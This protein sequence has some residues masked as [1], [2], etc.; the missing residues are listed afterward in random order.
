MIACAAGARARFPGLL[1]AALLAPAAA[2]QPYDVPYVPTPQVVVEEMLR[3]AQV[4]PDDYVIDLGC[5]DGR[6]PVTAASHFGAR[7]LGVDIDPGR[8]AESHANA[9]AAG[10]TARVEFVH[11]NLFDLD[12]SRAS[13]VT[14][15]LLPDINLKL[16]PKLL[17]T[18]KPGTRVVSHAFPMGDWKPDRLVM[19]QRNIYYWTIPAQVAGRWQLE[20]DLPGVGMRSYEL[21]V[22]QKYQEIEPFAKTEQRNYAVWEPRLEGAA[23]S[24]VIVDG[25]LAHRY[26]GQVNGKTMQGLVRTGAGSA[27]VQTPFRALW[28]GQL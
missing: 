14:M 19:V 21:E 4:R 25:D 11:G 7:A 23:I 8:I 1:L 3:I 10:V 13:V 6:I 18:L 15:Y 16:R 17:A 2:A 28:A 9:K 27:E 20:A 26:E 12:L 24:F 5:G 22:R